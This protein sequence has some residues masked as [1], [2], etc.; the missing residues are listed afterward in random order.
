MWV[1][2]LLKSNTREHYRASSLKPLCPSVRVVPMQNFQSVQE[3]QPSFDPAAV[4]RLPR[5]LSSF[6]T[7]G[8]GLSGLLL[9]LGTAPAMHAALG[10]QAIWVWFPGTIV[11][12]LLNL[13][14]KQLGATWPEISGGTPNYTTRLL[15]RYPTLARYGAIG[16]LMG[17]V[18]VPPMNAIIL[19]DVINT[20][21]KPLG[22]DCPIKLLQISFTILPFIVA[23]SG[24]RALGILHS[25]FVLPA[26]G[27]TFAFCMQGLGWLGFSPESPGMLPTDWS[28]FS[29]IA[30]AKWFFVAVYA[31]Y[32]CETASS[33]VADSRKPSA[34]LRCLGMAAWL[35][36]VVYLGGSWVMMRLATASSGDSTFLNLETAAYP[37]WGDAAPVLTTFLVSSGCLLASAT[38]VSNSPRILYQLALDDYLSPVFKATSP[39]GVLAP[40]L[41]FT[42]L[43]SLLCLAWGDVARVVMVTGTGYLVSMM[44]IHLGLW[45]QRGRPEVRYPRIALACLLVEATV[46]VVGGLAWSWQDLL[47]GLLLPCIVLVIDVSLARIKFAP[48][49]LA[50]WVKYYT[51]PTVYRKRDLMMLQVSILIL[52]ISAATVAGWKVRAILDRQSMTSHGDLLVVLLMIST[53]VGV[54]IACWTTLPQIAALDQARKQAEHLSRIATTQAQQLEQALRDLQQTQ[55][56]LIQTEKMSSLGQ[57]VAGVAHEINNPVNFIYG[58]IT[59]IQNYAD[60]LLGLVHLYQQRY[61]ETDAMLQERIAEIDVDFLSEDLPKTLSSLKIGANRIREIVLSLRNFSRL[62]EAEMKLVNLHEGIDSTLLILQNRLKPSLS[63]PEIKLIKQY[64]EIPFVECYASQLNQVFMNVINNAIDALREPQKEQFSR[65]PVITISTQLLDQNW[66]AICIKDNGSGIPL[67]LQKNLFDPFFT[68]KPVGK[69]TGLGLAISHQ[70]VVEKHGGVLKCNSEVGQGAEF[71]IQ[72]PIKYSATNLDG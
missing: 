8:F 62:D 43:M 5:S 6:E 53:F 27:L 35:I 13:Q 17:W 15:Q 26:V 10:A 51:K 33:F 68:T 40:S 24:T 45:L 50:W 67:A 72:I 21:I 38:A 60:D 9:W 54:A 12:I 65:L 29:A 22:I 46:L 58:N 37:F 49:H 55:S 52:L 71:W 7:W 1:P 59:Y 19:T 25:F 18:S 30:W 47:I 41:I 64:G 57:L 36:P 2:E 14:V 44:A 4:M 56:K 32:G 61:P 34:T 11:G 3:S 16:Y 28:S 63:Q 23:F 48:F 42:L 69:G 70:I 31:V 39:Q 20:T 66:I